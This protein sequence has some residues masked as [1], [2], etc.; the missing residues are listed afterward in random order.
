MEQDVF[1]IKK[2]LF[3]YIKL[4]LN[5]YTNCDREKLLNIINSNPDIV[6]FNTTNT[7]TFIVQDG[8]LLLPKAA[9]QI[10]PLLK[11]Y[12]NYGTKPNRGRNI[13]EYLDT[14]T[15]YMEYINHIIE[16]GLSVFDYFEE[17]LLHE[18][19]HI[20]GSYGSTP[21][22]EGINELKTR[23]LAQK[24][25]I[26]IAA[27]GYS[28]EVELAKKLQKIIGKEIMDELTFV[29]R[30]NRKKFLSNK[31]SDDVAQL[32]QLL[33]SKMI[34]ESKIYYDNLAHVNDPFEKAKLYE[35][36][37]YTESY[38]IIDSYLCKNRII[39]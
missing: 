28:K 5:N 17:S 29:P 9:Y 39:N 25:N 7:I 32:Y 15:T 35:S 20:C 36:I 16:S 27:Y 13:E 1:K 21:L 18:A 3:E 26:K 30:H 2:L 24:D 11:Q 4:I 14:N 8:V 38:Q 33:S 23:E 22:E 12:G 34:E 31:L 37:D 6:K 19:M 10:F